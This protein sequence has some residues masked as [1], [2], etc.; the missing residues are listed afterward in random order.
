MGEVIVITSGKGGVGKTT[1]T[2]N[3][4]SSLALEGKKVALIDTD[5]GLRNLDVVMGLENRIVYDIVDVVEG[6][7]KL[8]QA[9]IKDK[10][11]KELY[12]LPAAQTRDKSAVNE[13]QMK[14]LTSKLKEEFD[15]I[16]VDCP[17]GIE[18]G[19]KNAI[20]GLMAPDSAGFTL[21]NSALSWIVYKASPMENA[22]GRPFVDFR[23]GEILSCHIAV[24]HSV[25]DMLCQWYIAQ[26][27]ES[28]EEFPDELAGR[29]LE[30]V[31]SHEVGHVL[32][33]THNFYGSSLC[34]T[35]QLRD[36][37]FLH[38]HG[39]GSSIMDYM[40]MNYAVQPED[41]VD[42]SDRIPRIGAYD[43][44][45]IEWGYRY[46][47]GLAS[48]EIQEKLSVWIEKKQ[49]ERKY[50]FQDSGGNLPEAQAEDL[51]RY[52]LETAELGMCHLKRLLRDT[53]R[54]NG[55]LS[56]ESWNL[57]IRKQYSEYINQAFT[58]LGGIRKCWGNDS[59]IV[60]AVGRE[61]QQDALRFLQTYVLES[62]K[63]LPREWWED[64]GRET[65]RRLVEK[66]DC[67]VGYDREYS[68]TEYIRD[69]G[70]IFRNVSGEECWGRFL[71][72]CYTDCL[73][74]YIQTERNRYPE[75]VALME[76]Q[77]KVMYRKTDKEKDVFWKAWRK[78][79]NSIWK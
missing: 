20:A 40:R 57:A 7:C 64:W 70:K 17:A 37:V 55:R 6:K 41:G 27:G 78:N 10:R 75:V 18:Q 43:S 73:M 22:Y 14:E 47:P 65:V 4:G 53:L 74:E 31:V 50:R 69:L 66:A 34:E 38:R 54:N 30:M 12:L 24:F 33:L 52:S 48:E 11:F 63:D 15:Y 46:F 5:I 1:T 58:Y 13:E 29:L 26:T 45:A 28:E 56:V 42:M 21:D 59:V 36:A 23:T 49:L 62:G 32:G 3:L 51:G 8:R 68:V 67:F 39:Y 71:I 9:L 25:F 16:L 77:L 44:L 72:W 79:V 19:F 61:E 76:E 35:E 60:V 2:A